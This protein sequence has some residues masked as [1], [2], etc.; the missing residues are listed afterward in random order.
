M[1]Q[2]E[3]KEEPPELTKGRVMPVVGSRPMATP[4]LMKV[5]AAKRL[6]IP[7]AKNRP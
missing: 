1:I 3:I 4:K 6:P 2:Q 7:K 5:W